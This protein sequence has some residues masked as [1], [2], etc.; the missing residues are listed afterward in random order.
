M[1][2]INVKELMT[3]KRVEVSYAIIDVDGNFVR[4]FRKDNGLT[5]L[6]L[7]HILGISK[8]TVEKWEQKNC[9]VGGSSAV[10][11]TLLANNKNLL[12]QLYSVKCYKR[13]EE[14]ERDFTPIPTANTKVIPRTKPS[15][16]EE[17]RLTIS[18]TNSAID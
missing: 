4:N 18:T 15:I 6:E 14:S 3:A 13:G 10:L 5:Q 9:K 8:K 12:E 16:T 7:S 17:G 1:V 11:L 2:M